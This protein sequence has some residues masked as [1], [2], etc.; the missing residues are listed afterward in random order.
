MFTADRVKEKSGHRD[1]SPELVS[2]ELNARVH[3]DAGLDTDTPNSSGF[4]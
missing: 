2:A 1:I 4:S 3:G